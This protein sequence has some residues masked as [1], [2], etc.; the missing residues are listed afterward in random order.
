M[1]EQMRVLIVDD[2][3]RARQ[4][5]KAL[6]GTHPAVGALNEAGSGRE[7]IALAESW[8]PDAVLMDVCMADVNGIE[9]TKTIKT[10]WPNIKIIVLSMNGDYE[11]Q[12]LE[13]GADAFV[14]KG[15]PPAHLLQALDA[16]AQEGESH[17]E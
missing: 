4:S 5:M 16:V 15:E 6:V 1:N 10:H 12:A 17:N 9:A 11:A 13:A 7:A 3:A 14:N 8:A 2:L